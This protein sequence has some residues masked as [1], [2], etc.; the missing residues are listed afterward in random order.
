MPREDVDDLR[1]RLAATRFPGDPDN[2]DGDYGFP[3]QY[4]RELVDHWQHRHGRRG[5][6]NV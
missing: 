6:S 3:T 1:R 2:D 4:L 5:T